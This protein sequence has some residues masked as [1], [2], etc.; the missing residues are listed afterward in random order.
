LLECTSTVAELLSMGFDFSLPN[1]KFMS[2]FLVC[3]V[4][5]ISGSE[6]YDDFSKLRK[7]EGVLLGETRL[8]LNPLGLSWSCSLL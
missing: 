6:A 7:F 3:G 4:T 2:V 1:S 8:L 5:A